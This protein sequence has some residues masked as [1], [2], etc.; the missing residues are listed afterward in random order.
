MLENASQHIAYDFEVS[1]ELLK[2][3]SR[4]YSIAVCG[5]ALF[6]GVPT[7]RPT[8]LIAFDGSRFNE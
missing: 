8:L 1:Q 4:V 6:K 5:W 2:V 7:V 3:P